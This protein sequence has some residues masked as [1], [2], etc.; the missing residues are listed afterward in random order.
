MEDRLIFG[1]K[2][3]EFLQELVR[4]K[5]D[6]IIVGLSA[7]ALQ[8]APVVTQDIGLWFRKI[9][10]RGLEKALRKVGSI[11]VPPSGSNPPVFAGRGVELF[12][13]V[14]HMHG[15]GGFEEEMDNTI[16]IPLG[17]IKVMVLKL[18]RII[19]SKKATGRDKDRRVLKVL[20]DAL[21][22]IREQE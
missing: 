5:V 16:K 8:G 12:D 4:Q 18:E 14:T 10:D 22:T 9:P 21:K 13:I 15:L 19:D 3:F 1:E 17:R 20:S 2:E 11:Y 7:A 6:F